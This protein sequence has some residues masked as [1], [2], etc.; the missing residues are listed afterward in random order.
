VQAG[1]LGVG[2]GRQQ[3]ALDQ[4]LRQPPTAAMGQG[5]GRVVADGDGAG[6]IGKEVEMLGH[7]KRET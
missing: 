6:Q 1:K 2:E 3:H 7:V 5:N 4:H